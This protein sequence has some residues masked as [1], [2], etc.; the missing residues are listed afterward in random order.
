MS[1]HRIFQLECGVMSYDWGQK[2]EL[3]LVAQLAGLKHIDRAASYAELWMGVHP[4]C[5]SRVIEESGSY[6]SE[7]IKRDPSLLGEYVT[8]RWGELPF[9]LKILSIDKPLSIQAHPDKSLADTLHR[10]DPENYPDSNHKPEIAVALSELQLLYGLN[11]QL[12]VQKIIEVYPNIEEVLIDAVSSASGSYQNNLAEVGAQEL[13][14]ALISTPQNQIDKL[15]MKIEKGLSQKIGFT[16]ENQKLF[17]NQFSIYPSDIGLIFILFMNLM[18]LNPDDGLYL[19]PHQLHAYLYGDLAECMAN[20]DNV[21]RA[22]M[23]K[24]YKDL[25]TLK[26]MI[27]RQNHSMDPLCR[28]KSKDFTTCYESP[29]EEFEIHKIDLPKSRTQKYLKPDV[30]EILIIL[31]GIGNLESADRSYLLEKGTILFVGAGQDY[32]ISATE[33]LKAIRGTVPVLTGV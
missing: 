7:V 9:L 26:S 20:S 11:K 4:N 5:P 6:L 31:S 13:L 12:S 15:L 24:K 27:D 1:H 19:G 32:A 30:P 14:K 18:V 28:K 23:T 16:D 2:G 29:A 33:D 10:K 22:G 8:Q 21:I 3:S 25:N 17:L